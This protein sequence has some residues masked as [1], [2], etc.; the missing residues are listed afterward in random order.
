[1]APYFSMPDSLR[2]REVVWDK[3]G[4]FGRYTAELTMNR[5]Y[6]GN[7]DVVKIAFWV[8]PWNMIGIAVLIAVAAYFLFFIFT[9]RFELRRRE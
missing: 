8:I 2:Y 7:V 9:R 3:D 5:G 6:G 4:L 1:M